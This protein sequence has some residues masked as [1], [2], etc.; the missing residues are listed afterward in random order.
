MRDNSARNDRSAAEGLVMHRRIERRGWSMDLG[1][2]EVQLPIVM[3][4]SFEIPDVRL[5]GPAE[6]SDFTKLMTETGNA[7]FFA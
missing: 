2:D 4:P 7:L 6:F 3:M 5:L 1:C